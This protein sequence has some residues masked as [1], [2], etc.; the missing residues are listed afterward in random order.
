[1]VIGSSGFIYMVRGVGGLEPGQD[2]RRT[3]AS[4]CRNYD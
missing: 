2:A 1:M 3:E 4:F